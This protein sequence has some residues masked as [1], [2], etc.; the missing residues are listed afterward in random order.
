MDD[1]APL[2]KKVT[3]ERSPVRSPSKERATAAFG[4]TPAENL[5]TVAQQH[6]MV[7]DD[8]SP[9]PIKVGKSNTSF[10]SN[11]RKDI[12]IHGTS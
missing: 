4:N 7:R 11:N 10:L 5:A 3:S 6:M 9:S 12:S 8:I 2:T 1:E